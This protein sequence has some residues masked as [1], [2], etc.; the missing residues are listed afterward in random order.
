MAKITRRNLLALPILAPFAGITLAG[1]LG[2]ESKLD[3]GAMKPMKPM[4]SPREKIKQRFFP[5]VTLT[6][7]EG[8]KVRFYEDLIK[9]KTVV[10]NM[11]YAEC[12]GVCPGITSNLVRVQKLFGDQMGRDVFFYS[13]TL[14]PEKDDQEALKHYAKM[15]G[16][17]PGWLFLTGKRDDIELLRRKL[18][19]TNPNP[20][21]D[22]DTSQHIGN[23]RFGNEPH[24]QWAACPGLAKPSWIHE[25]IS[26]L[27]RR[28]EPRAKS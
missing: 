23:L 6:T 3:Q 13:F 24:M 22:K 15:H 20:E 21:L 28:P 26:W 27:M 9:D 11:M 16:V 7:H 14:K 10:I 5:D 25:S 18:G 2:Q 8:K 17:G 12:E 1:A 19:F 4:L